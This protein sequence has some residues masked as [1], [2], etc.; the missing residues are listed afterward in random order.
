MRLASH[1]KLLSCWKCIGYAFHMFVQKLKAF[2]SRGDKSRF[3]LVERATEVFYQYRQW[4]HIEFIML[5]YGKELQF[6]A[7]HFHSWWQPSNAFWAA[8]AHLYVTRQ[9]SPWNPRDCTS[10]Q[11][12]KDP[13]GPSNVMMT[14]KHASSL[15]RGRHCEA[16]CSSSSSFESLHLCLHSCLSKRVLCKDVNTPDE[17]PTHISFPAITNVLLLLWWLSQP[18]NN[19][20]AYGFLKFVIRVYP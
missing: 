20:D 16:L 1:E 3:S 8:S 9:I 2:G 5:V 13:I 4:E 10:P 18:Q 19:I 14:S 6:M 17:C 11:Q 15:K 7:F 12:S